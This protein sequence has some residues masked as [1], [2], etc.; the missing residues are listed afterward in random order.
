MIRNHPAN[1]MIDLDGGKGFIAQTRGAVVHIIKCVA[2]QASY[3][4][5]DEDTEE[6]PLTYKG[7]ELF[8]DPVTMVLKPN[9][10][11][12]KSGAYTPVMWKIGG[13]WFCKRKER[14]PCNEH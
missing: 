5:I 13:I 11:V 3:R 6:I 9:A 4:A 1:T 2:A 12:V 7:R 8:V 14:N 10:T